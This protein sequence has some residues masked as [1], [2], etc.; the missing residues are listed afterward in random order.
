MEFDTSI[1]TNKYFDNAVNKCDYVMLH[2]TAWTAPSIQQA[3]YLWLSKA[4]VSC[5][6][7]IGWWWEVYQLTDDTRCTWHAWEGEYDWIEDEM[8]LHAIWIEVCSDWYGYSNKQRIAVRKL[9]EYLINK[10]DISSDRIIRHRDYTNRKRDIWDNFW[11][12]EYSTFEQYQESFQR[13]VPEEVKDV[14]RSNS[15]LWDYTDDEKLRK[16]LS[17]TNDYLRQVYNIST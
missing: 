9:L 8:N 11:N 2:H 14:M 10:H 17:Q 16:M 6:Y 7:V 13:W 12:N 1:R 15:T 5:H 3:E 4:P